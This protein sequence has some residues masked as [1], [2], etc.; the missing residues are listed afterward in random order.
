MEVYAA[1]G[2][3][4]QRAM[5]IECIPNISEGRRTAHVTAFADRI[6]S[7]AG[8]R[9]LDH[10][11]DPAHNRSVFTFVGEVDVVERAVLALV[12]DAIA[13][14][15]LRG[16]HGE[17]PRIGAVDVVPFVPLAGATMADAVALARRVGADIARRFDLPVY[18]YEEASIQLKRRRLEDIR[19]GGFEGLPAKMAR[20]EWTPDFGPARP[21]PTAGA[22]AVGARLALVAYNI[23]LASDRLDIAKQIA[24]AVRFSSGGLPHVKALGIRLEDRGMVQVSMNLTNYEQTAIVHVFDAVKR[25]AERRG[26]RIA[27]SEIIGLVPAAALAGTTPAYLQLDGFTSRQIL[28]ERLILDDGA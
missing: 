13:S 26:V 28:E 5:L 22:T 2:I 15:D 19:R 14:I 10:S 12:A 4:L 23:N 20:P 25:E 27:A 7:V 3:I 17:H 24:A 11:A 6:R 1:A 9:L 8:A 18:L 16:H 21:H